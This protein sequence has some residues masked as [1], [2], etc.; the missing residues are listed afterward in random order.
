M[1]K[2]CRDGNIIWVRKLA[3]AVKNFGRQTLLIV[4]EDITE[5][6]EAESALAE[7]EARTRARRDN[8]PRRQLCS[9]LHHRTSPDLTGLCGHS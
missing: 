1:R 8:S 9:R 3:R 2:I 4:C 7:R 6:K 5:R